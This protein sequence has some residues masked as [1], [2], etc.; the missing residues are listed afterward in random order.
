ME[1]PKFQISDVPSV[2]TAKMGIAMVIDADKAEYLSDVDDVQIGWAVSPILASED[3]TPNKSYS[4]ALSLAASTALT[5]GL[6]A[7]I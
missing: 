3:L 2:T 5:L 1:T 7:V 6:L 4:G